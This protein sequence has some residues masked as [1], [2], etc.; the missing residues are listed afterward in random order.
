MIEK[1][2]CL[3]F[4]DSDELEQMSLCAVLASKCLDS[5]RLSL[6]FKLTQFWKLHRSV[7][8]NRSDFNREVSKQMWKHKVH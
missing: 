5:E 3:R 7:S 8:V 1:C 2:V 4:L 6:D